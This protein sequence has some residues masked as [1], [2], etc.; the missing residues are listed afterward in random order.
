MSLLQSSLME[1]IRTNS[2][3]N[4][5]T[6]MAYTEKNNISKPSHPEAYHISITGVG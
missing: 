1:A 5:T 6:F 3:A 2:L 4:D